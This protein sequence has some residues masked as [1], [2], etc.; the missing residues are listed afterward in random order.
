MDSQVKAFLYHMYEYTQFC[1]DYDRVTAR[2]ESR[3]IDNL[4]HAD[5][6]FEFEVRSMIPRDTDRNQGP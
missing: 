5:Q 2:H 3:L 6:E 4:G 1:I